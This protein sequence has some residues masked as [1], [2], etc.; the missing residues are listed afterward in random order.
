M[1]KRL[2]KRVLLI[3]SIF[4]Y[5]F[6]TIYTLT[7]K[8]KELDSVSIGIE[9]IIILIFSFYSFYEMLN[10]PKIMFIN[11]DYRFWII[12]GMVIYLAGT[13]FIYIYADTV[14]IKELAKFLFLTY[15]F[16][17]IKDIFFVVGIIVHSKK[18][19]NPKENNPTVPY[20]DFK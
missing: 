19:L 10:D 7:V 3:T 17:I 18:P 14:T 13:F 1:Q 16:Y 20:L 2:V 15:V 8:V 6:F 5:I 9:T 11:N 4:F 12:L